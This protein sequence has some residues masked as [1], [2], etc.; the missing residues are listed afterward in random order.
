MPTW[1][2]DIASLV[3]VPPGPL[4]GERAR[5]IERIADA[6]V[7]IEDGKIAWFGAARGAAIEPGAE[8]LSAAGGCVIPGLIDSHT[9]LPFA[10]ERSGEFRRR[11]AGESYEAIMRA[12]G[13]IRVTHAAVRA[14]SEASLVAQ[15][16]PR[17]E[18]MLAH[19]VTTCE[20][21]SGYGLS[22][23]HELKQLRTIRA[24][25]SRQPLELV[26]TFLGAHALPAEFEGRPDAYLD[27]VASDAVFETLARER[28]AAFCDVFCET[29]AFSVE[30]S[31]RVLARARRAGLKLK[32]HA[33]QLAQIGA[34]RLAAELGA[35][36]ADHLEQIDEAGIAALRD[37]GT[38]ATVL[39]GCTF[40]LGAPHADARRMLAAGLPVAVA[41]DLNPGSAHVESLPLV[42]NIACCQMRMSIEETLVACTANAAAALD[43]HH[44][45]GAIAVGF[46]ADLVALDCAH[47]AEWLYSPGRNRVRKVLKRGRLVLDQAGRQAGPWHGPSEDPAASG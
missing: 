28:L 23:E 33:D 26:P 17:L 38:I 4:S 39:P 35:T 29:V 37:A 19:G 21:K 1:I 45:L 7:R 41:T 46:D 20:C 16:L 13:G 11:L 2:T 3:V 10:G 34:S 42:M 44:R 27:E 40:F 14:A 32:L 12:G 18:R 30:Q 15:N 47:L 5:D 31:R 6:A 43:L 36:S 25:A 22:V 24:L 8:R 9:H